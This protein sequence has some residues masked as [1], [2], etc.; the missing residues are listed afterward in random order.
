MVRVRQ[1]KVVEAHLVNGAQLTAGNFALSGIAAQTGAIVDAH[2]EEAS[3]SRGWFDVKEKLNLPNAEDALLL[4]RYPDG[5]TQG[6]HIAN[7]E[8]RDGQS[9]IYVRERP[10]FERTENGIE[11]TAYPQRTIPGKRVEYEVIQSAHFSDE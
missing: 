6:Y 5:A 2:R 3:P 8:H 1:G 4:V 11:L 10:G 7:V 9:R